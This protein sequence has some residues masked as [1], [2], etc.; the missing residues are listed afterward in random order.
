MKVNKG[1][2]N[3]LFKPEPGI[4]RKHT[5]FSSLTIRW[6]KINLTYLAL[7][8]SYSPSTIQAW[9][10]KWDTSNWLVRD[11]HFSCVI[12]AT[13]NDTLQHTENADDTKPVFILKVVCV[14]HNLM[15]NTWNKQHIGYLNRSSFSQ[16]H[17]GGQL[18]LLQKCMTHF[19]N[20]V[21]DSRNSKAKQK[22][23]KIHFL[24]NLIIIIKKPS[25]PYFSFSF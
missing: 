16:M 4:W 3:S 10:M 11:L 5:F 21:V 23:F 19:I 7:N 6:V 17:F 24:Y 1:L 2:W 9:P 13:L 18:R 14:C 8:I 22:S 15:I 12:Y 25:S 20:E